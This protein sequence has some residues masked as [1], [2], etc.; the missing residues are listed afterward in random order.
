MFSKANLDK[1]IN[2][3]MSR[4]DFLRNIGLLLLSVIG[5]NNAMNILTNGHHHSKASVTRTVQNDHYF[6]RGSFGS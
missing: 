1:L 6:G 5:L 4:R 2:Q 3:P